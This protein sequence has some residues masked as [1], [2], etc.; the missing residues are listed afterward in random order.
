MESA[1][2]TL[3]K[4][5]AAAVAALVAAAPGIEV[6]SKLVQYGLETG[7][8]WI[9]GLPYQITLKISFYLRLR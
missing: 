9:Y 5:K 2:M 7:P 8:I 6:A 1:T 3:T 4:T